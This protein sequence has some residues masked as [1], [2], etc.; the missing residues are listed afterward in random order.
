MRSD[1]T[2]RSVSDFEVSA[3]Q[4]R[5]AALYRLLPRKGPVLR[6]FA[7]C[8]AVGVLALGAAPFI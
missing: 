5:E 4:A 8:V 7:L 3:L 2:S 6:V 1:T